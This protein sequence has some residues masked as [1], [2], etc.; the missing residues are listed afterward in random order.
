M[1]FLGF[2]LLILIPVLLIRWVIWRDRYREIT[3][4]VAQLSEYKNFVERYI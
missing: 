3:R 4:Q 2:L 1:D